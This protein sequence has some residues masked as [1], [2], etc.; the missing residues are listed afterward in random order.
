MPVKLDYLA[1]SSVHCSMKT[2]CG[3]LEKSRVRSLG[4]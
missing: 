3:G 2:R 4:I 1:F